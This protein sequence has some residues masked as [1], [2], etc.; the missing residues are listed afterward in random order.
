MRMKKF[1]IL[2]AALVLCGLIYVVGFYRPRY[3]SDHALTLAEAK[4]HVTRE[5][6]STA[7]DIWILDQCVGPG[8]FLHLLR[9]VEPDGGAASWAERVTGAKG[10]TVPLLSRADGE[11]R[12]P[13][14]F[15][16]SNISDGVYY[17]GQGTPI[18]TVWLDRQ[19]SLVY[20]EESD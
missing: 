18:R 5:I 8:H 17:R 16:P 10:T 19:R 6:P 9:F 2:A 11:P 4:K 7:R 13:S 1:A 20:F 15:F 3:E 14:W 12:W